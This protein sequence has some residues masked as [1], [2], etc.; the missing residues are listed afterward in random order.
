MADVYTLKRVE[1]KKNERTIL[2]HR[3]SREELKETL[4][5]ATGEFFDAEK[6]GTLVYERKT[7][8]FLLSKLS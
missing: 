5:T 3:G 2:L 8:A 6:N 7:K 4:K 1:R